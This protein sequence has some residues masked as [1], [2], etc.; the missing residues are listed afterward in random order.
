MSTDKNQGLKFLPENIEDISDFVEAEGEELTKS[1]AVAR[2][3]SAI[4]SAFA[5]AKRFPRKMDSVYSKVIDACKNKKFAANATYRFPRGGRSIQGPTAPFAREMKRMFGNIWSGVVITYD[6]PEMRKIKGY[7]WDLESNTYSEVEDEFKKLI[8]RKDPKTDRTEWVT[9]DERDLRELTNRRAALVIRNCLLELFPDYL[10]EEAQEECEKTRVAEAERDPQA[11]AKTLIRSFGDLRVGG[12]M[13]TGFLGHDIS[14][15]SPQELTVLREIYKSIA[16]GNSRWSDYEKAKTQSESKG[17]NPI[18]DLNKMLNATKKPKAEAPKA[19]EP[20]KEPAPAPKEQPKPPAKPEAKPEPKK[21]EPKKEPEKKTPAPAK[22]KAE[23]EPKKEEKKA[24]PEKQQAEQKKS[25]PRLDPDS[26]QDLETLRKSVFN[27]L[28]SNIKYRDEDHVNELMYAASG[29]RIV[30]WNE[31]SE[32]ED[33]TL[34]RDT[35]RGL[36]EIADKQDTG[37]F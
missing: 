5:I 8:Q 27:V 31:L 6:G 34:M 10:I 32:L 4:Q 23:P 1:A 30:K 14:S 2:E 26:I 29:G 24:E 33:M 20:P 9:P 7:A 16:D 17:S 28:A 22:A 36:Y 12:D 21:P 37:V 3:T 11:L 19:P 35:I 25:V 18:E 13:L 15:A